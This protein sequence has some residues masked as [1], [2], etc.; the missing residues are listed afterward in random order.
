MS[1]DSEPTD[2]EDVY[3]DYEPTDEELDAYEDYLIAYAEKQDQELYKRH[4]EDDRKAALKE[5]LISGMKNAGIRPSNK[6]KDESTTKKKKKPNAKNVL[7]FKKEQFLYA[8]QSGEMMTIGKIT[9]IVGCS[10]DTTRARMN[11]LEKEGKVKRVDKIGTT[12]IWDVTDI[13]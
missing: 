7:D 2:E 4:I 13:K 11:D 3:A 6:A 5:S 1:S 9:E 10:E 12:D 8:V